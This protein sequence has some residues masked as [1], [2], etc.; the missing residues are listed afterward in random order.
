VDIR[1]P[2]TLDLEVD[3]TGAH[4]FAVSGGV[5]DVAIT[6]L[7]P[8]DAVVAVRA[9]SIYDHPAMSCLQLAD[10]ILR[11]GTDRHDPTRHAVL[12]DLYDPWGVELHAITCWV[13]SDG[14]LTSHHYAESGV[15]AG[16]MRD[17][18]QGPPV[19]RGGV[20]L[21][22]DLLTVY[23]RAA[24][25]PISV[26]YADGA[27]ADPTAF[28]FCNRAEAANAVLGVVIVNYVARG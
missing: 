6:E 4:G 26:A 18:R 13:G 17:F 1:R 21:Q 8:A 16:I 14:A 7:M 10:T 22:V 12:A 25:E 23:D 24:L 27:E 9:L 3:E 15:A 11:S 2:L 19:D 28:R 5:V 20:P